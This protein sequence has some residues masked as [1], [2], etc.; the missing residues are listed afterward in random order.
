MVFLPNSDMIVGF[1]IDSF[2]GHLLLDIPWSMAHIPLLYMYLSFL[3][4]Y[5]EKQ[6]DWFGQHGKN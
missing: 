4:Q 6:S 3:L 5:R 1:C 2:Y